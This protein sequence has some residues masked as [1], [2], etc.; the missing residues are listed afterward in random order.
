MGAL[1]S[2]GDASEHVAFPLGGGG[3]HLR[4]TDT[5]REKWSDASGRKTERQIGVTAGAQGRYQ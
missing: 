2:D 5:R 4:P 3:L 1:L